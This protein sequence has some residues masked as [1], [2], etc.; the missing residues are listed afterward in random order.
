MADDNWKTKTYIVGL[1]VGAL[2]GAGTAYLLVR[3]AEESGSGGPPSISTGDFI[4]SAV[5]I[6]GVMRGIAALGDH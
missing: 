4:K 1:V 6:V 3:T 2:F 5:G